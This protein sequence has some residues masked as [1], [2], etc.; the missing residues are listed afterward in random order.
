MEW[1]GTDWNSKSPG[2]VKY[3]LNKVRQK[4]EMFY[5]LANVL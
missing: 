1:N 4:S 5:S 2:M 3:L